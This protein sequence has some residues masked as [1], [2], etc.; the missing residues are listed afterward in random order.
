[1]TSVS[2]S[3]VAPT[4]SP[5]QAALP[6]NLPSLIYPPGGPG[7][8]PGPGFTLISLL[9]DEELPWN[10]VATSSDSATQIFA[11][12]PLILAAG[13]NVSES[14]VLTYALQVYVPSSYQS[15]QDAD[16]LGTIFLA[17][18]PTGQVDTLA[19]QL[20]V[21][22]SALYN[23]LGPPY[24]TLAAHF[25]ATFP[26]G[27]TP[28]SDSTNPQSNNDTSSG[29]SGASNSS[30]TREDAIIGVVSSL[31]AITL[32][33]LAFLGVRAVKQR[34]ALAHRRLAE[35]SGE[36]ENEYAGARPEG[37]EFDRDSVGGQ[38]RRSFYYAEDS[39]RVHEVS[40]QVM[41]E[42]RPVNAEMIGA[43]VLRDNTMDW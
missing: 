35:P 27:S 28:P 17:Y 29:S 43:P 13:L 5:S 12:T 22:T 10:L 40:E 20:L 7:T 41:R 37:Q 19:Q 15:T 31:G 4:A 26:V 25:V 21:K 39:L 42:R 2:T 14:Q 18:I 23:A 3:S 1:M 34:R 9:F 33:V 6:A 30:K 8:N 38:R 32:I 24:N 36:A 11:W 16:E